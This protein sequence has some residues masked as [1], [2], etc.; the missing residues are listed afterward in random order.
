MSA[1][2]TPSRSDPHE[3]ATT[4]SDPALT[5]QPDELGS[6][7]RRCPGDG[8]H[9]GGQQDADAE[10][11][12]DAEVAQ[13]GEDRVAGLPLAPRRSRGSRPAAR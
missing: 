11:D 9:A 6:P 3:K 13:L 8:P 10:Q 7:G 1:T 2:R 5:A 4:V 12:Q